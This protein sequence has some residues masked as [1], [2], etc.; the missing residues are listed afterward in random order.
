MN[1]R[2]IQELLAEKPELA[3]RDPEI[4]AHL[5][6]CKA[7]SDFI[8]RLTEID[9]GLAALSGQEVPA[10]L[11]IRTV[12]AVQARRGRGRHRLMKLSLAAA[13]PVVL[14]LATM[15]TFQ[16]KMRE[17][18]SQSANALSGKE[19]D[20]ED[21]KPQDPQQYY[22][23]RNLKGSGR[24][25]QGPVPGHG[26]VD[27]PKA[28][29]DL[30]LISNT[31]QADTYKTATGDDRRIT[32]GWDRKYM[33]PSSRTTV[34]TL[35][36]GERVKALK[37]KRERS[38]EVIR[39]PGD[40]QEG[41]KE[42][43]TKSQPDI[44]KGKDNDGDESLARQAR[45]VPILRDGKQN[46]VKVY[47]VRHKSQLGKLG[48]K[49]G[50]TI[51]SIDGVAV[52]DSEKIL[53][54]YA[55]LDRNHKVTFEIER[56][57]KRLELSLPVGKSSSTESGKKNEEV[58]QGY[59]AIHSLPAQ[60]QVF[61]DG[62]YV[63]VSPAVPIE[64]AAGK[65][66]V[67]VNQ[68]GYAPY[69]TN[70]AVE[71][72][73]LSELRLVPGQP[74]LDK[75]KFIPARGY[76]KNTY[77]PGD[78][79][80]AWLRRKLEAGLILDG[81]K[82]APEMGAVPYRQPFDAPVAH[83]LDVFLSADRTALE[84]P[85][86]I[87]MQVGLKGARRAAGRRAAINSAVVVDLRQ[88]PAER[89]RRIIWTI[90]DAIAAQQQAG[91]R[92]RLLVAGL[93]DPLKVMP[94]HFDQVTVRSQ[95]VQALQ[96]V[97]ESGSTGSLAAALGAAYESVAIENA[98]DAPL[99][100][101]MVM[102][103]SASSLA[104]ELEPIQ[105]RVRQEALL[106][107]HFVAL[108]VGA[109]ADMNSLGKL[110]FAG[111]GRRRLIADTKSARRAMEDELTA[112]GRVV[113]RA[114][115]LRIRLAAGVKLVQVL[116]SHPLTAGQS[117]HERKVEQ[118][119]DKRIAKTLGID[120]DRGRDEDGIQVIIP[121]YYAGDDHVI[122]L[123]VVV[124]GPGKVADVR[125]RYKDLIGMRN[126]QARSSLSLAPGPNVNVPLALNVRKNVIAF[127]ISQALLRAAELVE[128]NRATEAEKVL[129]E[130]LGQI[131][132]M[133]KNS[134]ELRDDRELD[135]DARMLAEYQRVLHDRASWQDDLKTKIH[136]VYSLA[137][138]GRVK[139]PP[140]DR[141]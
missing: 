27:L 137:Y 121:A 72:G 120:S 24:A 75:L 93:A 53:D 95:L 20:E 22:R 38:F 111:Q 63:A 87:T 4:A 37:K 28:G 116:G 91:D 108:G 114:L 100:A 19:L 15:F 54:T 3:D 70:V 17:L 76:F 101:N 81:R 46:G 99:G 29:L 139:L 42:D 119:I 125:V 18:T 124:A 49:N 23:H 92:H 126:S 47:S 59:L 130:A 94:G 25:K 45:I 12:D 14:L 71:R 44:D 104:G 77:L 129:A 109:Q 102:L 69:Q 61:V 122:L 64:L 9:A 60:A 133:K 131:D 82:L 78:P 6:S 62:R 79:A 128:G 43:E 39:L 117:E 66:S 74:P 112:S 26:K 55:R 89:Q 35:L 106:G 107:I 67:R 48:I 40:N 13:V 134:A 36:T 127:R 136:L 118:F 50:D 56:D 98:E 132:F 140:G 90:V 32:D 123:D 1:C 110:A 105:S 58:A 8:R 5:E 73:E 30:G 86:R 103:I 52:D 115:R 141:R 113:A 96:Q 68:P 88:V 41:G 65:H 2:Q 83:G 138:A 85:A 84:G 57:G 135:G 31:D 51:K 21:L 80:L 10:S 16:G 97:E 11:V 34:E 33:P 7:C